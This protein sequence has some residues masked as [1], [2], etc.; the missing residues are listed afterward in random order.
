[1]RRRNFPRAVFKH[2]DSLEER[3][4]PPHRAE[5]ACSAAGRPPVFPLLRLRDRDSLLSSPQRPGRVVRAASFERAGKAVGEGGASGYSLHGCGE[6]RR[7]RPRLKKE[8]GSGERR[9]GERGEGPV[10]AEGWRLQSHGRGY[11]GGGSLG[12]V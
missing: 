9:R 1:M 2:Q 10:G 4:L 6:E 8:G 7:R 5:C 12:V 11:A 3:T